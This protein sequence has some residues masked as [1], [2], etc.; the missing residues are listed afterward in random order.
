MY[1]NIDLITSLL[2]TPYWFEYWIT[3]RILFPK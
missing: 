2:F 1:L 3:C